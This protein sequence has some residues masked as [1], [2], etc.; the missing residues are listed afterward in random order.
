MLTQGDGG[1]CC[2]VVGSAA[3]RVPQ[4]PNLALEVRGNHLASGPRAQGPPDPQ[5]R[6]I[7]PE[8]DASISSQAVH[9]SA[10][11][12]AGT[13]DPAV[14]APGPELVI[15]LFHRAAGPS[16]VGRD[17]VVVPGRAEMAEIPSDTDSGA[18][19]PRLRPNRRRSH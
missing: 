6:R 12:A 1:R 17:D 11:G 3:S 10:V 5:V 7:L 16:M 4:L 18:R 14:A 13:E 8:P 9:T 19:T 15:G 2:V